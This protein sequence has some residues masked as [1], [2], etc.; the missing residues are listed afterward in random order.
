MLRFLASFLVALALFF[1]PLA[2]EVGGSAAIAHTATAQMNGGC[3][4]MQHSLPDNQ[5]SDTKAS[6]AIACAALPGTPARV[7]EQAVPPKGERVIAAAQVLTGI[8]PEG[9]T[10]PPRIAPEI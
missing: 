5:K 3:A 1:S 8:W 6:C 2:M 10:P 7:C 9:E 4:G